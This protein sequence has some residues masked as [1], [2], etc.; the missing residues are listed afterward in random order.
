[1]C[2]ARRGLILLALTLL[3]LGCGGPAGNTAH[4]PDVVITQQKQFH[5]VTVHIGAL[6]KV[7][8]PT[9]SGF[10]PWTAPVSSDT[11][12]LKPV[13]A[14]QQ[15][16]STKQLTVVDYRAL[17]AGTVRLES[18]ASVHCGRFEMCPDLIR[19]WIVSVR[20]E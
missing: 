4:R 16:R 11:A 2:K 19:A 3:L 15:P 14:S 12:I 6:V 17:K 10:N 7:S 9:L 8:L 5:T 20:V 13:D 18:G 1:M